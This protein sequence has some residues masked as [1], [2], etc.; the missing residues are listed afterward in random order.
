MKRSH[1]LFGVCTAAGVSLLNSGAISAYGDP[2]VVDHVPVERLIKNL[3]VL[4]ASDPTLKGSTE[5]RIARLYSIAYFRADSKV[6]T[7]QKQAEIDKIYSLDILD[8][9]AFE[10]HAGVENCWVDYRQLGPKPIRSGRESTPLLQKAIEHYR[11]A[12][13]IRPDDYDA[14]LGLA[15]CL[16]QAG[17][18]NDAIPI[19]REIVSK[20]TEMPPVVAQ[21]LKS[22]PEQVTERAYEATQYLIPLLDPKK[23]GFELFKLNSFRKPNY[24]SRFI[25]PIVV[26]LED[27]LPL[28]QI[29]QPALVKFDLG[30]GQRQ[31]SSWPTPK[32]GWLVYDKAGNGD[33][34]TGYQL[35]GSFSFFVFWDNG[36]QALGALDDNQD[37]KI[38]GSELEHLAL[39]QDTNGDGKSE[40]SEVHPLSDYG[41]KALSYC[42]YNSFEGGLRNK[43]GV[44]FDSGKTRETYDVILNEVEH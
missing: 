1:Y 6:P 27:N 44:I 2:Q 43:N 40:K 26:P 35:F 36:Y 21:F 10:D 17:Q 4:A 32:A 9:V 14:R 31:Y 41:I 33:I 22:E 37:G 24:P 30:Y 29:V 15:W 13:K 18:K 25:T 7:Y 19:L 23:D 3:N 8:S 39:W 28:E 38:S 20:H 34:K 5:F 16:C 11:L 42:G 12:V